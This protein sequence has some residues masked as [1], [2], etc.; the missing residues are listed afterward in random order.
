MARSRGRVPSACWAIC[1]DEMKRT[2]TLNEKIY[3]LRAKGYDFREI[4]ELLGITSKNAFDQFHCAKKIHEARG[5]G[6]KL[7]PED[8]KK[9]YHGWNYQGCSIAT[10]SKKF[11][12][13]KTMVEAIVREGNRAGS[14]A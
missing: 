12:I 2:R 1:S 5:L 11:G 4:G 14:L 7:T 10:L 13:T 8:R 6:S 3:S 9:I